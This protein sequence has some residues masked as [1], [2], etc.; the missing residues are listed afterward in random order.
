MSKREGTFCD[1][2]V[3]GG[4]GSNKEVHYCP[5]IAIGRC[6]GCS[7]DVCNQHG[8]ATALNISI[9]RQAKDTT[10]YPEMIRSSI[11]MC[12]TCST[13]LEQIVFTLKENLLPALAD[14][15]TEGVAS[16]L[17]SHAMRK[18]P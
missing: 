4:R 8:S 7:S 2:D 10:S 16:T 13:K 3:L 17:A 11:P 14:A 18:T 1:F 5:N 9:Q 12:W 15:I 6:I